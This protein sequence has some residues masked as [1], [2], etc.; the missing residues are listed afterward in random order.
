MNKAPL[1]LGP[2]RLPFLA[3]TPAC[4]A[5]GLACVQWQQGAIDLLQAMLVLLGAIAAHIS[6]NAFNEYS[7]FKSGLDATTQR[8]P[9]SGGSGVLPAHPEL[10]AST[11]AMALGSLALCTAIGLYFVRL[12]G[13]AL[14]PLGL[15]GVLLIV[16]Y[17]QWITRQPWLC[18]VAPGLGFGPVM[19]LGT[20][21]ALTGHYSVAA[22]AAS[23]VPFF[24]VNNLLLLNQFP[25]IEADRRVGRAD[26]AGFRQHRAGRAAA[27]APA[28]R[29]AGLAARPAGRAHRA[30]GPGPR[31]AA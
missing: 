31:A 14:L 7:D 28:G 11:R 30:R 4:I 1:W 2:A 25:D 5:L 8:T 10:A 18:L 16:L 3:L 15:A 22:A 6:V 26:A 29:A 23:A 9:F 12:R 21:V 13:P 17:T 24:L 27:A 20:Q 19:I